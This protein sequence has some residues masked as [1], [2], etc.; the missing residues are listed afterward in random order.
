[1][2]GRCYRFQGRRVTVTQQWIDP[3]GRHM[4]H[5]HST[6]DGPEAADGMTEASF[7]LLAEP[8][9]HCDEFPE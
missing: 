5:V 3:Y 9:D 1:M 6:D 7:L 2:L 4:V 8:L